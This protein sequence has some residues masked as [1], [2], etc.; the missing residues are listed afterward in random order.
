[1]QQGRLRQ[2]IKEEE[3][4]TLLQCSHWE[5]KHRA[6]EFT[7]EQA[8]S[9]YQ[10]QYRH[11]LLSSCKLQP[12]ET[13][14]VILKW[15]CRETYNASEVVTCAAGNACSCAVCHDC[16][17]TCFSR[18]WKMIN[19]QLIEYDPTKCPSCQAEG[20]FSLDARDAA[21]V[22]L[23]MNEMY[24][25]EAASVGASYASTSHE[26]GEWEMNEEEDDK[27]DY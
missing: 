26:Q 16:L 7:A 10:Y 20:V 23:E 13:V 14:C 11:F 15:V 8:R 22:N 4:R 5:K 3:R 19:G 27:D 25:F 18:P 12:S 17:V 6:E 9:Q 21:A 2:S 1:M 24:C